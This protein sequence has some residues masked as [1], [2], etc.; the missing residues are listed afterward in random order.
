[1]LR[2]MKKV[3]HG[4][5]VMILLALNGIQDFNKIGGYSIDQASKIIQ[6]AEHIKFPGHGK[7]TQ[8]VERD[9]GLHVDWCLQPQLVLN[10]WPISSNLLIVKGGRAGS[11]RSIPEANSEDNNTFGLLG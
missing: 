11:V 8:L 3:L 7:M 4:I 6:L 5:F 10:R 9:L 1:M 2:E